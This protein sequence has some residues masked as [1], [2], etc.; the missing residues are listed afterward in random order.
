[1]TAL[2]GLGIGVRDPEASKGE[3][4]EA[5]HATGVFILLM[6]VPLRVQHAMDHQM[7][8]APRER[9]ARAAGLFAQ[10]RHAEH[11]VGLKTGGWFA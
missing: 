4:L 11:D 6:V 5:L 8:K 9:P 10:Y 2:Q 3:A 1:M 7:R